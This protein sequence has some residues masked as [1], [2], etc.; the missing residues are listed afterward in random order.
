MEYIGYMVILLFC[1]V[2]TA[3]LL[4]YQHNHD[5][6]LL[7]F[8]QQWPETVCKE[9]VHH[10][11]SHTCKMPKKEDSWAIHGIW[12]TKLGT[13]DPSFCNRTWLFDPEE[14]RPIE[15]DLINVWTNIEEGTGIYSFWAHEW[16]KHG[17]CAAVLEP[18]DTQYKYFS[19]GLNFFQQY[20]MSAVLAKSGIVPDDDNEYKLLD[21]YNAVKNT[22]EVNPSIQCR[23]EEGKSF[24]VEIRICFDKT[25][26][27][28]NCDG[29]KYSRTVN[30]VPVITNCDP[31]SGILYPHNKLPPKK[32]YVE[33]YKLVSW[34]QWLTL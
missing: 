23:V 16:N 27:L 13:L 2:N 22:L 31:S 9:W 24:L 18:L 5:W 25:L 3:H 21:I 33:L 19:K 14:I 30:Q 28:T 12:P 8:T 20:D 34:L 11:P 10:N 26:N 6:D 7:I 15:T 4:K 17:T 1:C 29:I 32:I